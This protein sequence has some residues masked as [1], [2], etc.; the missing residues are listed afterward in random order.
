M[1]SVIEPP[2]TVTL[3]ASFAGVQ[4]FA[5]EFCCKK[6]EIKIK[7]VCFINL[8]KYLIFS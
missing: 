6:K 3:D 4:S 5:K 8:K 2:A 1:I 7:S